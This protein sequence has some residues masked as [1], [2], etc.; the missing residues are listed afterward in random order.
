[1]GVRA[2]AATTMVKERLK[3]VRLKG[4]AES[5]RAARAAADEINRY[6]H[7]PYAL[8]SAV[9]SLAGSLPSQDPR[10]V[11]CSQLIA[12]CYADAGVAAVRGI[13]PAKVTPAVLAN[14]DM[15]DDVTAAVAFKTRAVPEHLVLGKF[16][17][18]SDRENAIVEEMYR[19]L[20]PF[21]ADKG[22]P[23]PKL[24]TDMLR[25]LADLANAPAQSEL[26]RKIVTTMKEA[27]YIELLGVVGDEVIKPFADWLTALQPSSLSDDQVAL[28]KYSL[29]NN[30]AALKRQ[31]ETDLDNQQFWTEEWQRTN[32]GTFQVL[33][34]YS[35][36]QRNQ[37]LGMI[38]MSE[39][40]LEKLRSR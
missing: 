23:V 18:L 32:L 27:G 33:A 2:R 19:R 26:D 20:R 12:Q 40:A 21:F 7:A 11:F 14:S 9:L 17:T 5:E 37:R 3:V 30:M 16:E 8:A 24:W 39:T 34:K 1:M 29:G 25:V 36:T 4:G 22:M 35:E 10:A 31:A 6:L 15:F 13:D 38:A 28:Y